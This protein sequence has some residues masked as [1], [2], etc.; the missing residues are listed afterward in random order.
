MPEVLDDQLESKGKEMSHELKGQIPTAQSD[1]E[2]ERNQQLREIVNEAWGAIAI[3]HAALGE[4]QR[5]MFIIESALRVR[6][7]FVRKNLFAKRTTD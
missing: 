2:M 6:E 7:E 5:H 1:D 3:A 4:A